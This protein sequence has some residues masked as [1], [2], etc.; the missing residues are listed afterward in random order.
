MT[1]NLDLGWY[2]KLPVETSVYTNNTWTLTIKMMDKKN[3]PTVANIPWSY[4]EV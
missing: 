1:F 4:D 3:C 2:I